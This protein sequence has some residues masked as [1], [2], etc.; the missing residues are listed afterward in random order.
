[1]KTIAVYH[2]NRLV[3][4]ELIITGEL[5]H[6]YKR[7]YDQ[8]MMKTTINK[9]SFMAFL[10]MMGMVLLVSCQG[11]SNGSSRKSRHVQS[12]A[13]TAFLKKVVKAESVPL[14]PAPGY[15]GP[16]MIIIVT[17]QDIPARGKMGKCIQNE[18]FDGLDSEAYGEEIIA[19]L[20]SQYQEAGKQAMADANFSP[21]IWNWEYNETIEGTEITLQGTPAGLGK[22]LVVSR[23][24]DYY[25]GG[26]HGMQEKQYFLFD[27]VKTKKINLNELIHKDAYIVL[28][29]LMIAKLRNIAGIPDNVPLDQGGFFTDIPELPENFFLTSTG[30]GF[31]WDPIEISPYVMG[32]IEIIIP[33]E[34]LTDVFQK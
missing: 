27:M 5:A 16:Q 34:E 23:S 20:R 11:T 29:Q 10:S 2:L 32:P 24:R 3:F 18:V 7:D 28:Q 9:G 6:A 12:D 13:D 31:H 30:L 33:Y 22:C 26:A 14:D 17:L 25:Q 8:D 19:T 4:L 1:M 21:G 15:E